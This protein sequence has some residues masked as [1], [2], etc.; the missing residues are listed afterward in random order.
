[1]AQLERLT[2]AKLRGIVAQE[3]TVAEVEAAL[4]LRSDIP[5]PTDDARVFEEMVA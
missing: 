4:V 2:L 1:M 5:N 3:R